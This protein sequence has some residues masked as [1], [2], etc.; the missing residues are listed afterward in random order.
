MGLVIVLLYFAPSMISVIR[1][2]C[3]AMAIMAINL[4]FGWTG[5][6]WL[7]A[8]ACALT[9]SCKEKHVEKT[10]PVRCGAMLVRSRHKRLVRQRLAPILN[11]GT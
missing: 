3:D 7:I 4:Y 6:G 8:A 5:I 11:A 9:S 1:R 2:R 10:A